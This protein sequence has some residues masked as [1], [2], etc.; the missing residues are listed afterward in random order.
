MLASDILI[1]NLFGRICNP[2]TEK[3]CLLYGCYCD[4][5]KRLKKNNIHVQI[6][7]VY[8]ACR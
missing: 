1:E 4:L 3:K 6:Y 8:N 7:I 2:Q 5:E